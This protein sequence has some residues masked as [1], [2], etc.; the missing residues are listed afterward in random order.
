MEVN[1]NGLHNNSIHVSGFTGEDGGTVKLKAVSWVLDTAFNFTIP[2]PRAAVIQA[3]R[4]SLWDLCISHVKGVSE[5]F[6]CIG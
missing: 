5:K 2:S 3:K 1:L 6:K 4:K